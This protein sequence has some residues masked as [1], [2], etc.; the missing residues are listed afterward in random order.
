MLYTNILLF[1]IKRNVATVLQD[2]H[3]KEDLIVAVDLIGQSLDPSR[4]ATSPDQPRYVFA[5]RDDL[6][7]KLLYYLEK[8][9][10]GQPSRLK[11]AILEACASLVYPFHSS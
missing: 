10:S 7:A 3:I 1:N 9:P 2:V 11:A 8:D 6:V 4:F 5:A